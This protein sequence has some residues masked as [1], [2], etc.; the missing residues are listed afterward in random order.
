MATQIDSKQALVA[1]ILFS[2]MGVFAMMI[3]PILITSLVAD[4]GFDEGQAGLILA[5]E[6][7][8]IALASI[9][10]AFWMNRVSWQAAAALAAATVIVGNIFSG[11][12][13]SFEVLAVVRFLVGF[14][15]EG[16]AFVL[17]IAVVSATKDQQ[18][19]FGFVIASQVG[20][21]VV[22]NYVLPNF[23]I[24]TMQ[25][26]GIMYPLAAL[27]AVFAVA[28]V[29]M[30]SGAASQAG[31]ADAVGGKAAGSV[32]PALTALLAM[33]VWCS[34]LGAI[35]SFVA[36]IAVEGG[37]ERAVTGNAIAISSACA[38]AGGI[39]AS[40]MGSRFGSLLPV[41]IALTVQ[42]IMIWFLQG[43]MSFWQFVM[44][45]AIFQIFWNVTGPFMMGTVSMLDSV[46]KI[47]VL[48]PAAQIGGMFLGTA[49]AGQMIGGSGLTAANQ[50]AMV[51][52]VIAFVIF[53]PVAMRIG[54][55][56]A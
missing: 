9:C 40:A 12:Q 32:L 41:G 50:V 2:V 53:A 6:F 13:T 44:T 22:A 27:A 49:V 4:L 38:I 33:F 39:A 18:R 46:G 54:K 34:G 7:L 11:F 30:P 1:A 21:G 45:A 8:G 36:Q 31:A 37:L 16:T 29:W 15:G 14:F 24:P 10:A 51:C 23:F 55:Q 28:I 5:I 52:C 35:W 42:V 26:G 19:N 43:E 47:S 17:G 3:G 20:F 25:F 48:I 56:T